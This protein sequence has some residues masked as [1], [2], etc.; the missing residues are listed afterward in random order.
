MLF[1]HDQDGAYRPAPKELVLT[2]ANK[3]SGYQLRRGTKILSAETAKTVIGYKLR[4][5]QHEVFACLFLDCQHRVLAFKEMFI[6]SINHA[7]VH[8]RE[9]VK[10][11]LQ[12]NATALILAH[13]HPSGATEP[14]QQDISLTNILKD[15]LKVIDVRILDHLV[16]GDEVTAFSEL[17][18]LQ[19]Q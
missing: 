11:A 15:I 7:T 2:E 3:L 1:V 17:G 18:L 9:I 4:G 19:E 14:S 6:G 5:K 13:N 8:P 12:L 10:E 16:V